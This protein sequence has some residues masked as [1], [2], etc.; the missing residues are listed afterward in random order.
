MPEM[1]ADPADQVGRLSER[2]ARQRLSVGPRK[3]QLLIATRFGDVDQL[4]VV[5]H[6]GGERRQ[7]TFLREPITQAAFSPDPSRNAYLF[8]K[9]CG[10][11]RERAALLSAPGGIRAAPA[12]R[13]QVAERRRRVV[14]RRPRN[15]VLQHRAGRRVLRHRHRGSGK[16]RAAAARGDRRRRRLVSARLVAGRSQASGSEIC[17][18]SPKVICTSSIWAPGKSARW[19]RP[20]AKVGIARRKIFA[21]RTGRLS[22]LGSRQRVREAALSSICSPAR[23]PTSRDPFRGTSSNWPISRDGHYLGLC[24]QRGRRQQAQRARFAHAPGS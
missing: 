24:Q 18:R 23:R 15:R 13:R 14:Q 7:I 19:I 12:D 16:R 17:V 10:R 20:P 22:D 5:D 4:H 8:L 11:Q 21:R 1:P 6:A 3:G 2:A 9:R